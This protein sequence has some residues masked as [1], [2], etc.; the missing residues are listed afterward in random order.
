MVVRVGLLCLALLA[1]AAPAA[2][3]QG[4][5]LPR[6]PQATPSDLDHL[7]ARLKATND[8][9]EVDMIEGM[10]T[11]AWSISPSPTATLLYH[12]GLEAM[13]DNDDELAFNLFSAVTELRPDFA[14]AWHELGAVNFDM[15]AHDAALVD[16]ERCLRLQPRHYGALMGLASIFELYGNKKAALEALRRAYAINPHIDGLKRR[17]DALSREV[18]GQGI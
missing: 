15:D 9:T 2:A 13:A 18:E 3:A 11:E 7:F 16:L 5:D 1:F 6:I 12:R 4:P 17:I 10:I 8:P 14:E